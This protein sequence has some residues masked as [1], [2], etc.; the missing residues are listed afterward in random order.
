MLA[1][2]EHKEHGR[3]HVYSNEELERHRALG[4]EP[5]EDKPKAQEEAPAKRRGRPK[6]EQ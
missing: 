3:M 6:K 4:W 5:V 2:L 1:L